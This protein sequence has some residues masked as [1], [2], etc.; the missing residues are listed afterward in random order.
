M[1]HDEIHFQSKKTLELW[2]SVFCFYLQALALDSCKV[3]TKTHDEINDYNPLV[4]SHILKMIRPHS[5]VHAMS[6]MIW[7]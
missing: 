3:Y 6:E 1:I 7:A 4:N 2:F 5:V